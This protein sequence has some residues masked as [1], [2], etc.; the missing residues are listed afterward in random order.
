MRKPLLI[1][2]AAGALCALAPAP[3]PASTGQEAQFQDDS[4]LVYRAPAVVARNLDI[5]RGLGVD[6]IRV[7]VFWRL[8]APSPTSDNKPSFGSG[9]DADPT[10]YPSASWRRYDDLVRL[11]AER[12]IEVNFNVSGPAPDWATQA[13]PTPDQRPLWF[14]NATLFGNFVRAVGKRYSGAFVPAGQSNRGALPRVYFWSIWNEPNQGAFLLPQHFGNRETSPRVYRELADAMYA[15][16]IDSGHGNDTILIGETAPRG[17]ALRTTTAGIPPLRFIRY[18]YCVDELLR[19][20]VGV[21]A[22]LNGCPDSSQATR[23]PAEHPVLFRATGFAHHPYTLLTPPFI[24]TR[25]RDNVG[26]ADLFTLT[27]TLDIVNIRY[28]QFGRRPPIYITEYGYQ[29]RPPD[30]FG[31]S[32][33]LA[34]AYVNHA[35][36]L[37][38]VNP[39]IRST[40]QFLLVDDGPLTAFP[41]SSPAYWN[42]F[43]SGLIGL[44]GRVKTSYGA[45]RMPL[46]VVAARRRFPGIFRIWGGVRQAPNGTRQTVQL[47]SRPFRSTGAFRTIRNI[48]TTNFRGYVDI[49][50]RLVSSQV[51][52]LAWRDPATGATF[53]S[54]LAG[55]YIGR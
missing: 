11:A 31:Y 5:M 46:H 2:L 22:R 17:G 19:P 14:P 38:Y 21:R 12:G 7:T 36:F 40:H 44:D 6:R 55:V 49:R 42:T 9:G 26:L 8:V 28:R 1:T 50:Q 10:G 4:E 53:Y 37:Q 16:L 27:R 3:A 15:G 39:R 54:R 29:T 45:Y 35:E 24:R 23:F 30:P 13:A 48:T 18:L 32:Q 25:I 47:Q 20:F 43:Q 41:P 51:L 52:R 33:P 34:A